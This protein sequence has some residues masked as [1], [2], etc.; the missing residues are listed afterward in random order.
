MIKAECH[1][2]DMKAAYRF[3][4]VPYFRQATDQ[5][6][7]DLASCNWGG[8]YPADDVAYHMLAIGHQNVTK[9]FTYLEI[10]RNSKQNAGFECHVDAQSAIV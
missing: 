10:I 5:A 6:I 3:D 8:D 7:I 2:D 9:M 4:A 1:S